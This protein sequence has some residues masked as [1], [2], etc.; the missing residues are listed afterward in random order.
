MLVVFLKTPPSPH[1]TMLI[2][3][4]IE[5]AV[6]SQIVVITSWDLLFLLTYLYQ[7]HVII[8]EVLVR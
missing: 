2:I 1:T 3:V 8:S 6:L 7:I 5:F 4:L